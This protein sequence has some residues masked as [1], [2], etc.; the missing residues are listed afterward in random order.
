[1]NGIPFS[2]GDGFLSLEF[3]FAKV[4]PAAL[5]ARYLSHDSLSLMV[6]KAD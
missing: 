1:M 6:V 2:S 3:L 4:K 5:A